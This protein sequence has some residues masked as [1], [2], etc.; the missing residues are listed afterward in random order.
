MIKQQLAEAYIQAMKDKNI[1]K[2]LILGVILGEIQNESLRG[3]SVGDSEVEGILRKMEKS[4]LTINTE[5][6]LAELEIIKPY[7]PQLM[8]E[9][10]IRMV[11]EGFISEGMPKDM[12]VLMK[13]FNMLYKGKADNKIVSQL[14]KELL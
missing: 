13:N 3:I 5:D 2:K 8:N 7:L 14:I 4:L 9:G 1:P 6:S 10:K 12:G 11:L